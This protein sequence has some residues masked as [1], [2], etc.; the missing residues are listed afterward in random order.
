MRLRRGFTLVELCVTLAVGGVV[1]L[2]VVVLGVREQRTHESIGQLLGALAPLREGSAIIPVDLRALAPAAGDVLEASDTVL[3]IQATIGAGVV[4]DATAVST[5]AP[6]SLALVPRLARAGD[7]TSLS[8]MPELGD[9]VRVLSVNDST[10]QWVALAVRG[11]NLASGACAS[12]DALPLTSEEALLPAITI[13]LLD[14]PP[15]TVSP[16]TPVRITRRERYSLYRA[17]DGAWYLGL[18][19]WNGASARF[20]VVQPLSGPFASPMSGT[21]FQALDTLGATWA[22]DVGARHIGAITL[23]LV[24][25]TAKS[26]SDLRP[27]FAHRE[28]TT[29]LVTPRNAR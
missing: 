26:I 2:L 25:T 21:R 5:S 29:V 12:A 15:T 7:L 20:D 22:S 16:G 4:C 11:A 19:E 10:E 8:S 3:D 17:S 9:S 23:T 27:S 18:R 28:S 6:A 14:A 1:L 13:S 24:A